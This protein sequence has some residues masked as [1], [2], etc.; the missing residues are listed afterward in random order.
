MRLDCGHWTDT[1]SLCHTVCQQQAPHA[2]DDDDDDDDESEAEKIR[3]NMSS[4][5][6]DN[7]S[8]VQ[9]TF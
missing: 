6:D 1:S 9:R 2:N 3:R 7:D 5:H 4:G 8:V